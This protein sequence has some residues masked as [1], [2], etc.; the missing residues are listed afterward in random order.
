M[1]VNFEVPRIS[2][3]GNGTTFSFPFLWSSSSTTEIF[4]ELND[5]PL[6]EGIEYELEDYSPRTGGSIVFNAVPPAGAT[7]FIFRFTPRTQQIVYSKDTAFPPDVPFRT[8]THEFQC[9]KDTRILQELFAA[10]SGGSGVVNLS[11]LPLATQV[12]IINSAG[13]DAFIDIWTTDG[14]L[15]G[16]SVGEVV[17]PGGP[18]PADGAPST[19]PEGYIYYELEALP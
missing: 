1:T 9:D 3:D 4:V 6:T 7:V 19:K 5:A 16:V 11:A 14:L 17:Q 13:S 8:D 15:A 10:G 12:Q 18:I 2:H